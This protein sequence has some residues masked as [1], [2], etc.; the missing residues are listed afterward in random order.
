[1]IPTSRP[2]AFAFS[3]F[4]SL[5]ALPITTAPARL[6]SCT[7]AEPMPLLTELIITVS[8]AFSRARV[9]SMCHDVAN[10]TWSAAASS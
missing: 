8:P 4:S 3:S 6:A 1:M 5:E 10:A 9:N 7:A 2:S